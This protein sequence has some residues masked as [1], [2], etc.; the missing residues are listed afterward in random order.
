MA[1]I[2]IGCASVWVLVTKLTACHC[3]CERFCFYLFICCCCWCI[4]KSSQI[5]RQEGKRAKTHVNRDEIYMNSLLAFYFLL[6]MLCAFTLSW[7]AHTHCLHSHFWAICLLV[8]FELKQK[9]SICSA[10]YVRGG[11]VPFRIVNKSNHFLSFWVLLF[12]LMSS[13][14]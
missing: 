1:L 5:L 7:Q 10:K 6:W 2:L 8:I 3:L 13:I 12:T 4:E 9:S 11:A 14:P